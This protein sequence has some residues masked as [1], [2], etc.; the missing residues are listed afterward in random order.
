MPA[1][2]LNLQIPET[3]QDVPGLNTP[4][5][6]KELYMQF[7]R[8]YNALRNV[9]ETLNFIVDN[10]IASEKL[11]EKEATDDAEIVFLLPEGYKSVLFEFQNIVPA[12][13]GAEF[14]M[15]FSN[16][17]GATYFSTLYWYSLKISSTATSSLSN[18][19]ASAA[20]RILLSKASAGDRISNVPAEA[21]YNGRMEL[22]NP[23]NANIYPVAKLNSNYADQTLDEF[24]DVNGGFGRAAVSVVDAVKFKMNSG[25]ITSG[26][27]RMLGIV[28]LLTP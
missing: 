6:Q 8:V 19:V 17:G 24:R 25:N 16:D 21:G 23:D 11:E 9:Q 7:F 26:F 20:S 10:V 13:D 2:R 4:E 5:F 14:E 1:P 28:D 3:P 22:F 18:E 15:Y 27:I 12:T